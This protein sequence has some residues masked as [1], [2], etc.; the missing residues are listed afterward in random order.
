MANNKFV[1]AHTS[2][3]GGVFNAAKN[4][5]EIGAKAFALFTKNQKRWDAKPF[6]TKT[7]DSWFK[8]LDES[9]IKPKHI[10]PHDS[11]LINLGN[12]DEQKL[13]KSRMA[14]IDELERCDILGLDRLNFHPGSHLVKLGAKDKRDTELVGK[15]ENNCL[16][17][18]AESI[19]IALDKTKNVTA[20]MENTAGQGTNLGYKFE[21]LAYIIDKVEDKSR[22]GVCI[23]TCHMFTAGYDIRT[24]ESYDK[25]WVEFDELIGSEYL[26][27]MHINDSKPPLG[28]RVDRH[29]SLGEG[30][31]GLDAFRFIMND[32]RMDDIPLVLETI[33]STIWKQEIELLYSFVK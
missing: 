25:T 7:L 15:I 1:G 33:D 19:N 16:D 5:Q 8:A 18:I 24:R 14:F 11:Y 12:P 4:A 28:S 22:I 32:E 6:D 17:L 9:G 20:V 31:I 2:A 29:H 13:I 27:G 21:H 10:L 30:E 23:D 3:S 26:K